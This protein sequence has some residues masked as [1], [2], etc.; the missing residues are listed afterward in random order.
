MGR[1]L[2]EDPIGLA[3]GINSYVYAGNDPVNGWDPMARDHCTPP[4][5]HLPN[6]S[7][8]A[9]PLPGRRLPPCP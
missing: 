2:S 4:Y 9:V 6:G 8:G 1:F 5:W 3:G 7:C